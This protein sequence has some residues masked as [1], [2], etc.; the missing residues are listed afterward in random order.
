MTVER[1]S[2]CIGVY[3]INSFPHGCMQKQNTDC[4]MANEMQYLCYHILKT[5]PIY[6]MWQKY[7][8]L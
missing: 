7:T 3:W 4:N 5:N 8:S 6:S 2:A 1:Q